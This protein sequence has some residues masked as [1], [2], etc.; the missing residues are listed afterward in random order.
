M[1][2][3]NLLDLLIAAT[4]QEELNYSTYVTNLYFLHNTAFW[5]A[6][7]YYL[8]KSKANQVDGKMDCKILVIFL[9]RNN[10]IKLRI[11]IVKRK[12]ING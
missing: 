9:T 8:Q 10:G 2:F 12:L 11:L 3:G 4:Y 6:F 7:L 1:I 5:N